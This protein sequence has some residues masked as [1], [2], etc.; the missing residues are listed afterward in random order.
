MQAT[1][2][3]R[4]TDALGRIVLP[5]ELRQTLG[6]EVGDSLELYTQGDKIVL[7][8]YAPGCVFCQNCSELAYFQGHKIC[9]SCLQDLKKA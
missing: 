8:K 2:I 9:R 1:G 3:V 5:T 6:I 4:K 7:K